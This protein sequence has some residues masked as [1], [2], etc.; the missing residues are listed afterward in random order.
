MN[1]KFHRTIGRA[2]NDVNKSN[3]LNVWHFIQMNRIKKKITKEKND[4]D[5]G[6]YVRIAK[7][8]DVFEKYY[9]P[10]YT[11]EIFVI[12]KII[13]RKPRKIY[14]LSDDEGEPVDGIFYREELCKTQKDKE[15][16]Y[17]IEEVLKKR[18]FKGKDQLFVK[19]KGYSSKQN[20]WI[21]A[22]E[23]LENQNE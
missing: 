14:I 9:T 21:D 10:N 4:L 16:L 18:K 23:L 15:T 17:R 22:R 3:V 13:E 12:T 11:D 8:K 19:F 5:V 2:P 6:M 20:C 1:S 7:R